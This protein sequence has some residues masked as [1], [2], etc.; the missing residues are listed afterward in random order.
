MLFHQKIQNNLKSAPSAP[1]GCD[2]ER[3]QDGP[4]LRG[5]KLQRNREEEGEHEEVKETNREKDE[6][7]LSTSGAV[8]TKLH[9]LG[10]RQLINGRNRRKHDDLTE[11]KVSSCCGWRRR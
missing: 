3:G 8:R 5:G 10:Q 11:H 9:L 6:G 1:P 2:R 7:E 4:L